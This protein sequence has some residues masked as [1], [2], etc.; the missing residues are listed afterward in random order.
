MVVVKGYEIRVA[1]C[2]LRVLDSAT[3]RNSLLATTN[4][5]RYGYSM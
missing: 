4:Y 1:S 3:T 2:E 5:I